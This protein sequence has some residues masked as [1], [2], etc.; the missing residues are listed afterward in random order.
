MIHLEI[1]ETTTSRPAKVK[2]FD[3]FTCLDLY[4][5]DNRGNELD[6]DI[7]FTDRQ[8]PTD[9]VNAIVAAINI[10]KDA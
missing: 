7:F 8:G 5:S 4:L 6:I 2:D 9:L 10:R 1:H 3:G